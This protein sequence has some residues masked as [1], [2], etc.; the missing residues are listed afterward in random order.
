MKSQ[1][2]L[3]TLAAGSMALT[4]HAYAHGIAGDHMFVSTFRSPTAV[5][6]SPHSGR[7]TASS[8]P[9]SFPCPSSPFA[10]SI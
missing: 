10:T 6:D 8:L 2:L 9:E 3:A 4:Q 7:G 1:Y 5:I